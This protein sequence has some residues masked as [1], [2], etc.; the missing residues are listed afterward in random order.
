[1]SD[2]EYRA[3]LSLGFFFFQAEDGIRDL[4]VTGVQT[5]ALP[6]F[7]QVRERQVTCPRAQRA[8]GRCAARRSAA[9]ARSRVESSVG[10]GEFASFMMRGI[11][12]HP[13]TT[14][15]QPSSFI[16]AMTRWMEAIASGLKTP[17]TS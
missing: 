11:S 12:V 9:R 3:A 2:T 5:C 14:A 4:Y 6:I 13:S 7:L 8:A 15:S 16:R 17:A 1:M 10:S